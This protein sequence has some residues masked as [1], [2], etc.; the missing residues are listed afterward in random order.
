MA[1]TESPNDEGASDKTLG[2]ESRVGGHFF[3]RE[4]RRERCLAELSP[5]TA[6]RLTAV[7]G[8]GTAFPLCCGLGEGGFGKQ[9]QAHGLPVTPGLA[10]RQVHLLGSHSEV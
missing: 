3:P 1:R 2:K 8:N 6:C 5:D 7:V 4:V 9:H 10:E